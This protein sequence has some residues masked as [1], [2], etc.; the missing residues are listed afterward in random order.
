M[1]PPAEATVLNVT[2]TN[3]ISMRNQQES[4]FLRL[5]AEIRNE[6]YAYIF[7]NTSVSL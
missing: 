3:A 4:P 7:D 1:V 5:P 2:E 6:I